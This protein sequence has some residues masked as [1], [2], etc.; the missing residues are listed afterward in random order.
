ME[1]KNDNPI[2]LEDLEKPIN[3]QPDLKDY[4]PSYG[5]ALSTALDKKKAEEKKNN[6]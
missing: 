6:D 5:M 1:N 3:K 4:G 2:T